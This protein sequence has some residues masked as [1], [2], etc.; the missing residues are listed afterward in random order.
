MSKGQDFK[1]RSVLDAEAED[2]RRTKAM[3]SQVRITNR[4][5]KLYGYTPGC[6]R[7]NDLEHGQSK[8]HKEHSDEFRLRM[9]LT[10]QTIEDPEFNAV[11]H[12]LEP[13]AQKD[14]PGH[15]ELDDGSHRR[16]QKPDR[17]EEQPRTPTAR[18]DGFI[19][20]KVM[21]RI[22]TSAH[23]WSLVK[24]ISATQTTVSVHRPRHSRQRSS[25]SRSTRRS[26][27]VNTY[28]RN[29]ATT[30]AHI[31]DKTVREHEFQ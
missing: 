15:V 10:S 30:H 24:S 5:I 9:Y 27:N 18:P 2:A 4:N 14:N 19:A 21:H 6:P 22:Q 1:E 23:D 28:L 29:R 7:C 8:T 11:R 13:D 25:C 16:S 12:I 20:T 3:R 26:A 17:V 31:H